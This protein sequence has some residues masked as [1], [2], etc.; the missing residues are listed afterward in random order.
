[1]A[2]DA[3]GQVPNDNSG[4]VPNTSPAGDA[5]TQPAQDAGAKPET[6]SAEYVQ[7]LRREA[8]KHR[9]EASKLAAELKTHQDAQL[10]E[11]EKAQKRAEELATAHEQATSALRLE[12]A[13]NAI[14]QA[15]AEIGVKPALA[16]KL[17]TP[18][19]QFDDDGKPVGVKDALAALVKDNPELAATR[20]QAPTTTAGNPGAGGQHVTPEAEIRA[21]MNAGNP[22]PFDL[23]FARS[24]GGGAFL[25]AGGKTEKR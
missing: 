20:T 13:Q 18:D 24:R 16:V 7:E 12:R 6:F 8:A 1:M 17:L 10:S 4:Q 25:P 22:N 5:G 19:V 14:L 3:T 9:T 2:E 11:L 23:E 15:A 21:R